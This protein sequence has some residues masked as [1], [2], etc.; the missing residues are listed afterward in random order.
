MEWY[1][2]AI[3]M[4]GTLILLSLMGF[5]LAVCLGLTG[6]IYLAA[7]V[8]FELAA[9]ALNSL[10]VDFWTH[11]TIVAVPLF[12][13]M[14]EF[15]FAG[16]VTDGLFDMAS[17]WLRRLP[18]GLALA[19]IGACAIFG[20]MSGSTLSAITT[21]GL[22]AVPQM[23]KR[24]YDKQLAT[25]AVAS[26]GSLAHLI[27]P[28][29]MAILYAALV[30]ISPGQQLMAGF[31]PGLLLALGFAAVVVIWI[32]RNSDAAPLEPE[33]SWQERFASLKKVIAPLVIVTGVL[34]GI[35]TGIA[36][37]TEAAAIGAFAS[38]TLA[39]VSRR[40]T[41]AAFFDTLMRAARTASFV[42][43][44]A[45]GGKFFGWVLN[46]FTVPQN[47]ADILVETGWNRWVIMALIQLLFVV[48]GMFVDPVGIMFT[49]VPI[50]APIVVTFG[51]DLTWFGV[52]YLINMELAHVTPPLGFGL[53]IIKGIVPDDVSLADVLWGSMRFCLATVVVLA[54]VM[55]FSDIALWL[56]ST[57]VD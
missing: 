31:F 33:V 41:K 18:G 16:G 6:F 53:Y 38:M 54:L 35:Y 49:T 40:L 22:V 43:F 5:P 8:G 51:F 9:L 52:L 17:K 32:W 30:E 56:P 4:I 7:R 13:F 44:I 10:V 20:T 55:A 34:G 2:T 28:S 36:T 11:Y 45:V 15:L 29:I 23:L 46:Y 21:F 25:G 50:L 37:V 39:A 27:P 48:L 26:A 19:T 1:V 3:L 47:I 57:M 42:L 24:G 14:A 12:I